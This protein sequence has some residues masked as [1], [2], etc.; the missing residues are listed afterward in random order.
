MGE[1]MNFMLN[2][3]SIRGQHTT[4]DVQTGG[5]QS[6]SPVQSDSD[7]G[8]HQPA[9]EAL[10]EEQHAAFP[11]EDIE[12]YQREV[13]LVI[14]PPLNL[15][16]LMHL[17]RCLWRTHDASI[18]HAW[19]SPEKGITLQIRL[20]EPTAL[21]KVLR[22]SPCVENVRDISSQTTDNGQRSIHVT[23]K[24]PDAKTNDNYES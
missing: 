24:S 3:M 5:P 6:E 2:A 22:E 11:I 12:I 10:R 13:S 1:E 23:L 8:T 20:T 9:S 18:V 21:H 14:D 17:Y 15:L 16:S 4:A 7:D 19:G